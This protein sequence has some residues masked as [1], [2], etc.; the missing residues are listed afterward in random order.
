MKTNSARVLESR[1]EILCTHAISVA[2][3]HS[4]R[5]QMVLKLVQTLHT[6]NADE[7]QIS[8]LIIQNIV[9]FRGAL[10][11]DGTLASILTDQMASGEP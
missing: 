11:L 8:Y 1:V 4:C 2:G 9:D 5:L 6:F 3:K 7:K 10:S